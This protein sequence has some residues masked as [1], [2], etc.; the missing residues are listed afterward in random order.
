[1]AILSPSIRWPAHLPS[2]KGWWVNST[3]P[4]SLPVWWGWRCRRAYASELV[5]AVAD[6]A[7]GTLRYDVVVVLSL[8]HRADL[9]SLAV[10]R[11]LKHQLRSLTVGLT[12]IPAPA[13]D[14]PE[15]MTANH[16]REFFRSV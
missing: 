15:A 6:H 14:D 10:H 1:M 9:R 3:R 12:G 16:L 2:A 8:Q 4:S 11:K 7:R 5:C 13:M